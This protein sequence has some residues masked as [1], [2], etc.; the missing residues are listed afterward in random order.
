MNLRE[1][2]TYVPSS[3]SKDIKGWL[4]FFLFQIACGGIISFVSIFFNISL[5]SYEGFPELYAYIGMACDM[6]CALGLLG[7][8][9][10]TLYAFIKRKPNAVS[11]GKI[12]V[13][14]IML[15]NIAILLMGELDDSGLGSAQR[16]VQTL[17]WNVIWL[18][19][20]SKSEQVERLF[21]REQRKVYKRDFLLLFIFVLPMIFL[22]IVILTTLF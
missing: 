12:V 17:V 16:I 22:G 15:T 10:Y 19:Y 8:A 9:A 11:L 20:L 21:P 2:G 13:T 14:V 3:E 7:A 5:E 18:I 1:N 6:L 4:A